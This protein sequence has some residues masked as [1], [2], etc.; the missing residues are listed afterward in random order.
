MPDL[1]LRVR[2]WPPAD[3]SL[4]AS[5]TSRWTGGRLTFEFRRSSNDRAVHSAC[6]SGD[7]H[8][9]GTGH[10]GRDRS[11][12]RQFRQLF[13]TVDRCGSA[14]RKWCGVPRSEAVTSRIESVN[15]I[16]VETSADNQSALADFGWLLGSGG[17]F[18]GLLA[19]PAWWI[20]GTDGLIGVAVS[21]VLVLIPG[22]LAVVLQMC[23]GSRTSVAVA[24][25]AV[26]LAFVLSGVLVAKFFVT[27]FGMREFFV[28]LIAF[29]LFALA[30]ETWLAFR[31]NSSVC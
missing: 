13:S 30:V 10:S 7:F 9:S 24:S 22:C 29:Y 28:W 4:Q 20:A 15:S 14:G 8:F 26:R 16:S 11:L 19:G 1:S 18:A 25:G 5:L 2:S 3:R 31:R 27:G 12:L 21:A 6:P 23:G 17:I